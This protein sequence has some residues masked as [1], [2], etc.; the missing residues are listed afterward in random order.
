LLSPPRVACHPRA[1]ALIS[2]HGAR[3]MAWRTEKLAE[4]Q[5]KMLGAIGR[6]N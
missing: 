6:L 1:I 4:L 3:L 5:S 2:R